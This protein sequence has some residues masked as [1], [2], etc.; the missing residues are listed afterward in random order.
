M[1]TWKRTFSIL[2][3]FAIVGMTFANS[4]Q[5]SYLNL[6]NNGPSSANGTIIFDPKQL[7]WAAYHPD[8]TLAA[9]G[10]ASGG[11][12]YC[13]DVKRGC[14]TPVGSFA[15]Y[16]KGPVHCR[17]NKYPVGKGGAYMPHCMFFKGGYAIHGSNELPNFNASH[18]CIRV[19]PTAANWLYNNFVTPGT[20]VVV[21]PYST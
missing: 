12:H 5:A 10:K 9:S 3:S 16:H 4:A 11:R 14:K 21:L 1:K 6:S 20:R 17:S 15:V 8:G 7:K 19:H 13:A 2:A 18:G